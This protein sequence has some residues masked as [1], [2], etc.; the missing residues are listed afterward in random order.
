MRVNFYTPGIRRDSFS[1]GLYCILKHANMLAEKG[2]KVNVLP[3]HGSEVPD[4]IDLKANF[5]IHKSSMGKVRRYGRRLY[6]KKYF[7]PVK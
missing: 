7:H 1:G 2:Y 4:W 3:A 5:I 6:G